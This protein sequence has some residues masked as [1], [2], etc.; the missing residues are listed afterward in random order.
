MIQLIQ[1]AQ[2]TYLQFF[3]LYNNF[4]VRV[5]YADGNDNLGEE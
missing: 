2:F 5:Q 4:S 3:V 1:D